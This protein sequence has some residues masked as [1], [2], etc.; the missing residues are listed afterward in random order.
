M[1]LQ[2]LL[3]LITYGG[4][5]IRPNFKFY[6]EVL[7]NGGKYKGH[8]MKMKNLFSLYVRIYMLTY[9]CVCMCNLCR[10]L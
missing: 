7:P 1:I 2:I 9:V 6:L 4:W 10:V 5:Q 8:K 3:V